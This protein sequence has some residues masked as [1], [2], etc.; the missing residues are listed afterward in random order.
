[1]GVGTYPPVR[2]SKD[3]LYVMLLSYG[4]RHIDSGVLD[5]GE[6]T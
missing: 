6:H 3:M 4:S 1:M 5:L 2:I